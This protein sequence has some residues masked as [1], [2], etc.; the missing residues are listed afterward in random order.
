[1][2]KARTLADNF[3]ADINGITA[4]TGITGGGTSGTVT[5]TNEMAT[6]IDAK[7]DLVV[8]TGADTFAR[9]AVGT[10]GHT[11]VADSSTATG[12]AYAAPAG[13]GLTLSLITDGTLSGSSLTLSSL[14]TYDT[15]ILMITNLNQSN[16]AQLRL[17]VNAN[18]T[19]NYW[20][21]G[22]EQRTSSTQ[23][24][25]RAA[26]DSWVTT[27]N[28]ESGANGNN[29]VYVLTNC[30]AAGFTS[31]GF[32]GSYNA[33]RSG[34]VATSGIYAVAEAVSSL[35]LDPTAGTFSGGNY[36]IYGG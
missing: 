8:G 2:T 9:L 15:L 6:T 14:S 27:R 10:N 25:T 1:M 34:E 18:S 28:V 11:L 32:S 5:V 3:A 24:A 20:S 22:F 4:G 23:A 36:R 19:S 26:D 30:K 12:L 33:T 31:F 21:I 13:G 29:F 17:R 16:A 7:G 35:V